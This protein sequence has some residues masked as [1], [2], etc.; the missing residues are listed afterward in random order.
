MACPYGRRSLIRST[1]SQ[2]S[3]ILLWCLRNNFFPA[4]N[5]HVIFTVEVAY[6]KVWWYQT[7]KNDLVSCQVKTKCGRSFLVSRK[8]RESGCIFIAH[9]VVCVDCGR[10]SSDSFFLGLYWT[11][12]YLY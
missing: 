7:W 9:I 12:R 1:K 2:F 11:S 5:Q 6:R 4:P 10:I 8:Q 3:E